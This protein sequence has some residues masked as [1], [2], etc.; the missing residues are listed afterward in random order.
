MKKI[1]A[2]LIIILFT[3]SS[4]E[5]DDICDANTPTTPRLVIDF[6]NISNASVLKNVTNL[7]VIG[8]GMTEGIVFNSGASGDAQYLTNGSSISIPLK[9]DSNSTKY[10]FIL[11]SGNP[12]PTL[13]DIDEVTFNYTKEDVFVSRACGFKTLFTFVPNNPY[14]QTAVP[15]TKGKWMQVISVEKSNIANE[16]ETHIKVFF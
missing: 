11:N 7:K 5:K 8:D 2:L 10:T 16:N 4:C 15:I 12:N 13:I 14:I 6:Y 1:I 3:S 9:T